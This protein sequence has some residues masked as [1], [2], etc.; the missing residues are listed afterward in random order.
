M[1]R[2]CHLPEDGTQRCSR[3]AV[4][5]QRDRGQVL[6]E[7]QKPDG[8]SDET[9]ENHGE[10]N[11]YSGVSAGAD[12]AGAVVQRFDVDLHVEDALQ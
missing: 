5:R 9:P 8:H 2:P 7:S 12:R 3:A 1:P 4:H 10:Y 11:S 6:S